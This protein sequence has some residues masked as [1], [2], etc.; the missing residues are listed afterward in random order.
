MENSLPYIHLAI[1][2]LCRDIMI[3]VAMSIDQRIRN[4]YSKFFL[5]FVICKKYRMHVQE[6]E[7]KDKSR[8][9]ELKD[10]RLFKFNLAFVL[11]TKNSMKSETIM[12]L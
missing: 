9:F 8:S 6:S 12:D 1:K 5:N 7:N 11:I 2:M 4:F 10:R 3:Y